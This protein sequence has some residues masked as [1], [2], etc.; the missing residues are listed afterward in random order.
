[1]VDRSWAKSIQVAGTSHNKE[2]SCWVKAEEEGCMDVKVLARLRAWEDEL[3]EKTFG[4]RG[5]SMFFFH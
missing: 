2:K 4:A 1:M 5:H 3:K